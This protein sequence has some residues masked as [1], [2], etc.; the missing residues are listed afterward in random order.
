M[1]RLKPQYILKRK[2]H[3]P[4]YTTISKSQLLA[5]SKIITQT[6]QPRNHSQKHGPFSLQLIELAEP[7]RLPADLFFRGESRMEFRVGGRHSL[8]DD[9]LGLLPGPFEV[10]C[11]VDSPGLGGWGEDEGDAGALDLVGCEAV[12]RTWTF[13][14]G[15]VGLLVL[16][17]WEGGH[18]KVGG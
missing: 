10:Y 17:W 9:W 6:G 18:W 12:H 5:L 15:L 7:I 2:S 8:V 3:Y 11:P 16:G 14:G 4:I 1:N 13:D